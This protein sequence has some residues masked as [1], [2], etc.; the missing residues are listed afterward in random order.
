MKGKIHMNEPIM[1]TL[2]PMLIP[3]GAKKRTRRKKNSKRPAIVIAKPEPDEVP[4]P[5]KPPEP[6]SK[7]KPE[8]FTLEQAFDYLYTPDGDERMV[9]IERAIRACAFLLHWATEMG[10]VDLKGGSATGLANILEHVA[11]EVARHPAPEI[12]YVGGPAPTD[13]PEDAS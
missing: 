2:E 5:P 7:P 12:R 3:E 13:V 9:N 10:N 6:P 1:P 11:R 4:G 8:K